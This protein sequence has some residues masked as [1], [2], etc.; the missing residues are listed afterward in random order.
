MQRVK[1]YS[2][3]LCIVGIVILFSTSWA[4]MFPLSIVKDLTVR[5]N[6]MI[7][8]DTSG[9]M[10]RDVNGGLLDKGDSEGRKFGSHEESR[11]AIAKSVISDVLNKT[12]SIANFGLMTFLQTH[13]NYTTPS[14]GYFTYYKASTG[15]KVKKIKYF[16]WQDLNRSRYMIKG[17][18]NQKA[19]SGEPCY[20]PVNSFEYNGI[21]YTL[22][23][24]Y[25]SKYRRNLGK[26]KGEAEG[27]WKSKDV[28]HGYC[29]S[30]GYNCVFSD[31]YD[32]ISYTWR[33]QGS[34][35]EY[36]EMPAAS[37]QYYYFKKYYGQQFKADG[38]EDQNGGC[39]LK[40]DPNDV[41]IYYSGRDDIDFYYSSVASWGVPKWGY[42]YPVGTLTSDAV[43]RGGVLLVPFSFSSYQTDQ[44]I[45][46]NDILQWMAPQ[47]D[48]GLIAT[49]Y[50]PTGSTLSNKT[51]VKEYYN[52]FK[53]Y[54]LA[55]VD[56]NDPLDCRRNYV[57][58]ITDGEP[59]PSSEADLAI[60]NADDLFRNY[61]IRV[62]MV[63]FG[64]DTAGSA[65]LD[66]IA[67][68]G[69]CPFK[70]DGHYAY[71]ASN[72]EELTASLKR[73]IYEASAGDYATSAPTS[74]TGSNSRMVGNIG[75]LSTCQFPDW[76]GHLSAFDMSVNKE[77]WDAGEQLDSN[78][79]AYNDRNIF[80]SDLSSGALVP[81]FVSGSPNDYVLFK[82]GLGASVNEARAVIEFI[83][84][85]D[86][87]WRL[88]DITNCTP[89]SVGPPYEIEHRSAAPGHD[90]FEV[91]YKN[92]NTVV[93]SGGNDCMLHCFNMCKGN[94]LFAYV[95]PDLLSKLVEIYQNQGQ[96]SDPSEHIFG[97]A[98]SPK[99]FDAFING[100]WKT[101]LICGE[102][103]GGYNY[104]ALDVTHPSSGDLGYDASK[105]FSVLWH[106]S[107]S[108]HRT[109]Y[110]PFVGESWSTASLG[111][112][113]NETGGKDAMEYMAFVGSGYDDPA[114]RD[115]EGLTFMAIHFGAGSH[116][117]DLRC[118]KDAGSAISFVDYALVA[119]AVTVDTEGVTTDA[120]AVD[121]AG[122]V[123][124]MS[125]VGDPDKWSLDVIYNAGA[126]QPFFYSP[127]VLRVGSG[128]STCNMLV[129][130]SGT[131]DDPDINRPG[132]AFIS[133]LHLLHFD[134]QHILK[135]SDVTLFTDIIMDPETGDFFPY[136]ARLNS[137][138]II[139]KNESNSQY[140]TLFL[141]YV[142]PEISGCDPGRT[143]LVVLK[144]GDFGECGFSHKKWI[145]TLD[146][147]EGKV[148]GIDIV[149]NPSAVLVGVSGHGTCKRSRL[150]ALPS[151]PSFVS[152]N[153][154]KLYW[155]DY[156]KY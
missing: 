96:P 91:T 73:I 21:I 86:N 98:A 52:D 33:Y 82:L 113:K 51:V 140:E 59:T 99:A 101:V 20:E 95:P 100:E 104:F 127:P 111:L 155:K 144:L 56:I 67:K 156:N 62:Y 145:T 28:D 49:G 121:T 112:I 141:V 48:G 69:G 138:P 53:E 135:D 142:P 17:E 64:S 137:S 120:Y 42:N 139:I 45:K 90:V 80:T 81:F 124:H 12:K 149:G 32:G 147:G 132:S 54:F 143:Y 11:L 1:K 16:S 150:K 27:N 88:Y 57:L 26:G 25:N 119:D 134:Y 10:Q 131:Y 105:P 8:F 83:A 15:S 151:T 2:I 47:N 36:E 29:D 38:T 14:K 7:I 148:T 107:D 5:P 92:R 76:K 78:H 122:K 85:K 115:T 6:I 97:L 79:I 19:S 60:A 114:S 87:F 55:E 128:R 24:S 65:T 154:N 118:A 43:Y 3:F 13:Y 46:V 103:A 152:G 93:Y 4:K 31:P 126:D 117:G 34:Y 129:V 110:D 153:V 106:T 63:G 68:A 130:G 58:F 77:L 44:D 71:Y 109:S 133:K 123:W 9:S 35:Y 61:N 18:K 66:K 75:L 37:T 70:S 116:M 94:E 125:T 41:F 89:V 74:G 23:S 40:V 50:T 84:G 108:G 30:C 39:D 136:R 102:G 146:A 22:I 72:A